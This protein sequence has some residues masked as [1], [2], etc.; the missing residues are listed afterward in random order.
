MGKSG[1]QAVFSKAFPKTNRV[2]GKALYFFFC[3]LNTRP[4]GL[5]VM[6]RADFLP[7]RTLTE[8]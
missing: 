2:L 3:F 1:P 8:M 6:G 7:K 4:M 5:T